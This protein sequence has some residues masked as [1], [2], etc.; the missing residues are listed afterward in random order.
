MKHAAC[1]IAAGVCLLS[2]C[3][4]GGGG[5]GSPPP[6]GSSLSGKLTGAGHPLSDA[7]ISLYAA[8]STG[9]GVSSGVLAT[10]SSDAGGNWTLSFNC[11]EPQAQLYVVAIGGNAGAGNNPAAALSAALGNCSAAASRS[12][13][14]DEITTVASVYAL[15]PFLDAGGTGIGTSHGNALGLG[16]AV[17]GAAMLA[18]MH[19]GVVQANPP[20]GAA[21]PIAVMN[22]LGNALAACIGSGAPASS[23]CQ[24][25]F[26]ATNAANTLQAALNVARHP[27]ANVAQLY[28]LASQAPLWQPALAAAPADWSLTL[29]LTGSGLNNPMAV[30]IDAQGNA[31]VANYHGSVSKFS[32]TGQALSGAAGFV[33]GGLQESFGI[34]IDKSGNAWVTNEESAAG[35]NQRLGSVTRLAPDGSFL[36]GAS[37]YTAGG[38]AFPQAVAIDS[39]G[40]AWIANYGDGA[41]PSS[42]TKLAPDGS[43]LSPAQG[44]TGGGLA[45]PAGL[46]V[47]G[48][49]AVWAS[50]QGGD[51]VSAL[52]GTGQAISPSS[53]FA[54][55]ALAGPYGI[56]SDR[57]GNI[58]IADSGHDAVVELA[59][60]ATGNPGAQLSPLGGYG[61]GTLKSPSNC[62]IDGAGNIWITNYH[63]ASVAE[64]AASSSSA[65]GALLSGPVG[66]QSGSL[67]LPAGLAIDGSGNVWIA[68][69]GEARVT[70]LLG[71]AAPVLTPLIGPPMLP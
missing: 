19:S 7:T 64:L 13:V 54:G 52:A 60:S 30:A 4:G 20:A 36:S 38:I 17:A 21:L 5:G 69:S 44:F 58:W 39:E 27:A 16:N 14:I 66:Y 68:N 71:A 26:A 29:Q 22:T 41:I 47:A 8:G 35:V 32:P 61:A 31:W 56:C 57:A 59:D 51:S 45:F 40:N 3:S 28:A 46:T 6:A 70:V 55:G 50:N 24:T 53:G 37:G 2:A 25:L 43:A 23:Q 10:T 34:A 65:P 9:Y 49:G 11:P 15:A 1:A 33:G 48:D 18:D 42:L 67:S 62:A 12:F 63:G